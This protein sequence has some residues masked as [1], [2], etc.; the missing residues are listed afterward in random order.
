[1]S[2]LENRNSTNFNPTIF[3]NTTAREDIIDAGLSPIDSFLTEHFKQFNE[4]INCQVILD[5]KQNV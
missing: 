5:I 4:D 3:P 1:M 2:F